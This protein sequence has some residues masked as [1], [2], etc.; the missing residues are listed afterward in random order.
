[1]HPISSPLN[2]FRS[3][4][5]RLKQLINQRRNEN[6]NLITKIEKIFISKRKLI[7][8]TPIKNEP[9]IIL[10]T[11]GLD[12]TISTF[13]LLKFFHLELYPL[14]INWG[15]Q[16]L[17]QEKKA[18]C[19]FIKFFQ[20]AF[21][22]KYHQPK[23]INSHI[24]AKEIFNSRSNIV[25]LRNTIF[26]NHAVSY[27]KFLE[28]TSLLK[29]RTIFLNTTSSDGDDCPDT[30]LTAIRSTNLNICVNE[31]DYNWQIISWAI[32]KEF[33]FYLTKDQ[34]ITL[35]TKHHLPLERTWTCYQRG[36]YQ[37]GQCFTCWSRKAAFRKAGI[38]DHTIY[39]DSAWEFKLKHLLNE[40]RLKIDYKIKHL[41]TL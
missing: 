33:G 31:N 27:A 20:K 26:A 23:F 17:Q 12:S 39:Y 5:T 11:G 6:L 8:Q 38:A 35:A 2:Q 7:I 41:L 13:V 28:E 4:P 29:I 1:M 16:N 25:T 10:V 40:I 3:N 24:P 18:F 15:Q 22:G 36:K 34:T 32:E 14:F 19:F 21:P 9:C 30:T 37:C